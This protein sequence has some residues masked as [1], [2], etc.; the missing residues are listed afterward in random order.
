[1]EIVSYDRR[2]AGYPTFVMPR[3]SYLPPEVRG[4]DPIVPEGTDLAI[5]TWEAEK[6][7]PQ[8]GRITMY[9]GIAFA[10]KA[11]K[12][13]WHHWFSSEA[14]RQ[15]EIDQTVDGR[16]RHL[17]RK[18]KSMQDRREF[19]HGLK[20]GDILYD[21][22]GYD[23]TNVNFY[24][25]TEVRGK[26]VVVREIGAKV[27]REERGADYLE[28]VP[29]KFIGPALKRRPTGTVGHVSVKIDDV[30]RASPWDGKPKYQTASGWGH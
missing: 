4:K 23:Q 27:V 16:R 22:W 11:N 26:E 2:E 13:L 30:I 1:M 20:E 24:Q 21:S 14:S 3:P 8:K 9:Y 5:W 10:G 6:D 12:P 7:T 18:Q 17:E 28:A 19:Q 15:R 25:V 29:G